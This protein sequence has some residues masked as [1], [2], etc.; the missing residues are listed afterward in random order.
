[1]PWFKV[2]DKLAFH[3]KILAAGNAAI[4]LWVRAG[5][6]S[7]AQQTEGR[8]PKTMLA[9]LGGR[10]SDARRLVESGLWEAVGSDYQFHDWQR[11]QPSNEDPD[12]PEARGRLGAHRRWHTLKPSPEC[13]YCNQPKPINGHSYVQ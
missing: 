8:I 13:E 7:R 2:D 5:S 10:P 4:G 1:M 11:Y 12:S 3:P 6:W 9:A